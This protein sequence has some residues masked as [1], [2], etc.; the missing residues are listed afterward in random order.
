MIGARATMIGA[1]ATMSGARAAMSGARP[2]Y[3]ITNDNQYRGRL[4]GTLLLMRK[5]QKEVNL[6]SYMKILGKP[7][8]K[9]VNI[10]HC[11]Y[12][13]MNKLAGQIDNMH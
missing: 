8:K 12:V 10:N 9:Q 4:H 13:C 6:F 3:L 1:R 2:F 7:M 5:C 11:K